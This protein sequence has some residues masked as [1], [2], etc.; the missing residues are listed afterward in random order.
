MSAQA[1]GIKLDEMRLS[2][3]WQEL[4]RL[5]DCPSD[6]DGFRA[7]VWPELLLLARVIKG[8][9]FN[10]LDL[11]ISPRPVPGDGT[12]SGACETIAT[13]PPPRRPAVAKV[14]GAAG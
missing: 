5:G 12:L 8:R 7:L 14:L 11:L 10:A 9:P 6:F 2:P 13:Q 3:V 1:A 4:A